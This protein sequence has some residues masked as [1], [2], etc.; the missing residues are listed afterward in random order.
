MLEVL[1]LALTI[2]EEEARPFGLEIN[3][4]K[5]KIQTTEHVHQTGSNA[6]HFNGN[7]VEVV[8]PFTYLGLTLYNS[9]SSWPEIQRRIF[10]ALE[11]MKSLDRNIWL[12]QISLD[13]KLRLYKVYILPVLLYG[14]DTWT[15]TATTQ[16]KID[17]FDT[18]YLRRI[19]KIPWTAHI[20]NQ[21]VRDKT[22]MKPVS[23]LIRAS[24]LRLFGHVIRASETQ[25]HTRALNACLS[26][27]K[28][29]KRRRGRPR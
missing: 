29:W 13:T 8:E 28:T 11:C 25:D 23:C 24:R 3:W 9:G 12:S 14:A 4:A 27:P 6:A 18:W 16:R 1:I 19:L 17:A 26:P 7:P 10:I 22:K 5:T 20:T 21:E 15:I 2:M